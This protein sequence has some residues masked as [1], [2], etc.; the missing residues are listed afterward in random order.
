MKKLLQELAETEKNVVS[1]KHARHGRAY[2]ENACCQ[3]FFP[4][5][6]MTHITTTTSFDPLSPLP[7]H[8]RH[9][10][11]DVQ[12]QYEMIVEE[13]TN[14]PASLASNQNDLEI[15]YPVQKVP[16]DSPALKRK[17]SIRKRSSKKLSSHRLTN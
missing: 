1:R 9:Q 12:N 4:K 13:R 7:V 3:K 10:I 14:S 16:M 15:T 5:E 11:E 8:D 6:Q 17:K 2:L